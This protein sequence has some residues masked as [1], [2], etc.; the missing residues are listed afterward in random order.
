MP[1][2]GSSLAVSREE[3][4]IDPEARA[5]PRERGKGKLRAA[6]SA[7][8]AAGVMY[9]LVNGALIG[10]SGWAE[11]NGTYPYRAEDWLRYFLPSFFTMRS[12]SQLY[13]AGPS[14]V[15]ENLLV[16]R[17]AKAFPDADVLLAATSVATLGSTLLALE[18]VENVYGED[19]LP[20]R[21]VVGIDPR[22]IAD[23]PAS[24]S[25]LAT[26]IDRYSPHYRVVATSEGERLERKTWLE[27]WIGRARF[28]TKQQMRYRSALCAAAMRLLPP[29]VPYEDFLPD[30]PAMR[31]FIQV[32]WFQ[33]AAIPAA[34]DFARDVGWGAAAG[35][36]LRLYTY[37]YKY[38]Y[39][40][41][42]P[43]KGMEGWMSAR[44]SFWVQVHRWNPREHEAEVRSGIS[45]LLAFAER[46]RIR[47]YVV[48]LPENPRSLRRYD[49]EN[50]RT[51]L[52]LVRDAFGDTPFLDLH[53]MFEDEDFYDVVHATLGPAI[54][55]SDR[56]IAFVREAEVARLP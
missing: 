32:L 44:S 24:G 8:L 55:L 54:R 23:M 46:H 50:Y 17:F 36:W 10:L 49:P 34:V 45:R 43:R 41:P 5:E 7:I 15:R 40:P 13:L 56:V 22:F 2:S 53:D 51:Y 39:L 14:S 3:A 42:M 9:A 28:L 47:L 33:P 6:L 21:L 12:G 25:P 35:R 11:R 37:P 16:H 31:S 26:A 18:Y 38:H 52:S 1:E 30:F 29:D 4:A 20:E 19:A 27:G 48:N